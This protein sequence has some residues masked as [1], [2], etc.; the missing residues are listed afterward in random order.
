MKLKLVQK[1]T[2]ILPVSE[3][4][5]DRPSPA[6]VVADSLLLLRHNLKVLVSTG[7]TTHIEGLLE[8][9]KMLNHSLLAATEQGWKF[10][11][12]ETA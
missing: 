9:I 6:E 12:E 11:L 3:W 5:N 1:G 4:N 2:H 8:D 10:K 7:G